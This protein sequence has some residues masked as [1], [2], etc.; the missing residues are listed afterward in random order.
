MTAEGGITEDEDG[1]CG[2]SLSPSGP[3][4]V[5]LVAKGQFRPCRRLEPTTKEQRTTNGAKG[6]CRHLD[7]RERVGAKWS[8]VVAGQVHLKNLC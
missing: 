8:V 7:A 1:I 2:G 4:G 6:V 3:K 5:L